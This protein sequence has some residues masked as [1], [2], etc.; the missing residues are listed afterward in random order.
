MVFT[1]RCTESVV[2]RLFL[3]LKGPLLSVIATLSV[4]LAA[5]LRAAAVSASCRCLAASAASVSSIVASRACACSSA[6]LSS[7][8]V[9][10][11]A[12]NNHHDRKN[13]KRVCEGTGRR[14]GR[15]DVS[16]ITDSQYY[17]GKLGA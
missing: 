11:I 16:E 13:L 7:Y 17:R 5:P 14:R 8:I 9:Q 3:H 10:R 1:T 12:P 4:W 2:E 6:P 15:L